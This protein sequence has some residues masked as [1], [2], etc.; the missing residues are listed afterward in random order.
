MLELSPLA[1][2]EGT[3]GMHDGTGERENEAE[4]HVPASLPQPNGHEKVSEGT[5]EERSEGKVTKI[6]N[7]I[8]FYVQ[9]TPGYEITIF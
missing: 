9:V 1:E 2:V 5:K 8:F 4:A 7:I 6:Q 3:S